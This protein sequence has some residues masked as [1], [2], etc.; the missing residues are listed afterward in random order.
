[1]CNDRFIFNQPGPLLDY[2]WTTACKDFTFY[3]TASCCLYALYLVE[4]WTYFDDSLIAGPAS[5]Y[6]RYLFLMYK[7]EPILQ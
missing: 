1:M 6:I 3:W 7:Y 5:C 4:K 2:H